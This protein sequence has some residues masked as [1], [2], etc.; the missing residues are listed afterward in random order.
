MP[1]ST[2]K[3]H[4]AA[5]PK[6]RRRSNA[7]TLADVA[8]EAGVSQVAVSA[9]LNGVKTSARTSA[10][11]RARVIAAAERLRYR[12]NAT[13][14]ALVRGRANAVGIVVSGLDLGAE[15]NIYFLEV[16]VGVIEGATHAGQTTSVFTLR[17]WD[18]ARHRI[19]ALCDGRTDGMILLAPRLESDASVW[20][21]AST[22]FVSVHADHAIAGV[23]NVESDDEAGA[24][25]MVSHMLA[26]GHRQ[27][28]RAAG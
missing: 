19:P 24:F 27:I 9:V 20:M 17:D 13:A 12:P 18:E 15:T 14:R 3:P 26:L 8:R 7:V 11:T 6:P 10:E 5:S 22:P 28:L 2:P 4:V 21:P 16:L 25:A 1:N 23:V